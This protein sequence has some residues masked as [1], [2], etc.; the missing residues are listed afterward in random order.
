MATKKLKKSNTAGQRILRAME[1]MLELAN[2]DE[3]KWT[4]Y[5]Y[6]RL[7]K[8]KDNLEIPVLLKGIRDSLEMNRSQFAEAFRFNKYSVRNW[9]SG[10]RQPPE[11]CIAYLQLISKNP[12]R[13][14][15]ELHPN[16]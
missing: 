12:L 9:E 15:K 16:R 2:G 13:A 8:N 4:T 6:P 7:K 10:E 1:A 11:Y 5:T 3:S 14:Y